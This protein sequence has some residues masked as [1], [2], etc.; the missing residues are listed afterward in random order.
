RVV[1][2]GDRRREQQDRG[3]ER[4]LVHEGPH[5]RS[6][7]NST[8]AGGVSGNPEGQEFRPTDRRIAAVIDC[9]TWKN[10]FHGSSPRRA[11]TFASVNWSPDFTR[12][13]SSHE[14]G[15]ATGAPGRARVEYAATAVAPRV[16]RKKSRK[17]FPVRLDFVIVATNHWGAAR[18]NSSAIARENSFRSSQV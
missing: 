2:G 16:L 1:L 8:G 18:T 10:P 17:I 14:T 6:H 4:K 5:D 13:S 12:G 3:Q 9:R 15:V 7:S 11:G